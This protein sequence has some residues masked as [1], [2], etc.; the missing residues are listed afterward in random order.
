MCVAG[1][2]CSCYVFLQVCQVSS[3]QSQSYPAGT[4]DSALF[5]TDPTSESTT[6]TYSST[7]SSQ[8]T[9]SVTSVFCRVDRHQSDNISL[10][11]LRAAMWTE[12]QLC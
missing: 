6:V 10:S 9:R 3:D 5:G 11:P 7:D 4:V 12:I 8:T 1:V 2:S